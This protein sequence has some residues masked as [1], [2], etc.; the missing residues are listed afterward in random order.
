M[1]QN[2]MILKQWIRVLL[3]LL[4]IGMFIVSLVLIFMGLD[5]ETAGRR[6][7]YTYNYSTSLNYRVYLKENSFFTDP[8]LG[9]N[10]QYIASIIDHIEVDTKYN[11]QST[12]ELDYSYSYEI[13]ATA[14]SLYETTDGKDAEVWSRAYPISNMKTQSGT[15]KSFTIDDTISLDYATY[16]DLMTEFRNQFGLSVDARVDL[17]LKVNVTAGLAGSND[18]TLQDN[19]TMTLKIPLLQQ[20]ISITPDYLNSGGNTIYASASDE[21]ASINM[22]MVI[23]GGILLIISLILLRIV[24]KSLLRVTKKSEYIINLNKILKEYGD[25][26]AETNNVPNLSKYEVVM[27]KNFNDLV[28]VEEELHSPIICCEVKEDT[29]CWFI[30]LHDRQCYKYELKDSDFEH[31]I[32][33]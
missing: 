10:R 29:E 33:K 26:I 25:I 27:L 4:V 19:S 22:P 3:L 32:R 14:K 12:E 18:N 13:V 2:K 11:F 1:K 8:Y 6:A 21:G 31:I 9:M 17:A 15:G 20:T 5:K 7:L 24:V 16:N 23:C 30:I 28:D